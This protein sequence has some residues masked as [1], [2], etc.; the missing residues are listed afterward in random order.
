MQV[1]LAYLEPTVTFFSLLAYPRCVIAWQ[2]DTNTGVDKD[3][4]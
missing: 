4:D 3:G 2:P 1:F